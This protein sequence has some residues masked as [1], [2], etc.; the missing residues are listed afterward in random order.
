MSKAST[1]LIFCLIIAIGLWILVVTNNEKNEIKKQVAKQEHKQNIPATLTISGSTIT[2]TTI[3]LAI[4]LQSATDIS[5]AQ[6]EIGYDPN[7]LEVTTVM[8]GDIFVKAQVLLK[9]INNN[10]GRVTFAL[11]C[12]ITTGKPCI[13]AQSSTLAKLTARQIAPATPNL[14]TISIMPK[15][16]LKT[17]SGESIPVQ[18]KPLVLPLSQTGASRSATKS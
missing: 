15:T 18:A 9:K 16:V 12:T 3:P 6:I 10:S 4:H 14:T 13:N 17:A 7:V 8:P 1:I 5:L 2:E 11:Q